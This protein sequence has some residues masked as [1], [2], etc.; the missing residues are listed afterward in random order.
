MV[1][2]CDLVCVE[3]FFE[4]MVVL[5]MSWCGKFTYGEYGFSFSSG[6]S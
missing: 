1:V 2:W 4:L 3:C 6:G 5:L